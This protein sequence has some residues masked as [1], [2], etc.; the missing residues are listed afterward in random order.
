MSESSQPSER[1]KDERIAARFEVRFQTA[2]HAALAIKAAPVNFSAGGLCVRTR[3]AY[4]QGDPV[5]LKL[6]VGTKSLELEASVA[7]VRGDVVGL[8]FV[9]VQP[10]DRARLEALAR[11]LKADTSTR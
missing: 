9:N 11:T 6:T 2:T 5:S 4:A 1:R 3:H 8:R 7:W 10:S